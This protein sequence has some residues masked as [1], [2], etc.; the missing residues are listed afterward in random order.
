KALSDFTVNCTIVIV[1]IAKSISTLISSHAS[2]TRALVQVPMQRM[3]REELETIIR[4]RAT[5]LGLTYD[6]ESIWRITFLSAGLPFFTHSLGKHA[7]LQAISLRRKK[8][9]ESDV[10][11]AMRDC[12]ADVDY[13]MRESYVKAT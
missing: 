10:D 5:R 6:E 4:T 8:I 3:T 11:N 7:A 9:K 12:H 13:S 2:I 1:G